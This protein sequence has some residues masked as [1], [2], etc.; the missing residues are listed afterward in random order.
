MS[1]TDSIKKS[2][3]LPTSGSAQPARSSDP[4]AARSAH[5]AAESTMFERVASLQLEDD[6]LGHN[7]GKG[8]RLLKWLAVVALLSAGCLAAY[9]TTGWRSEGF[10]AQSIQEWLLGPPQVDALVVQKQSPVPILFDTAGYL[11][12]HATVQVSPN[13]AG[14]IVGLHT[15]LGQRMKR[16]ELLA[17]LDDVTFRADFEKAKSEV[18]LAKARYDELAAG[19]RPEEVSEA[20]ALVKQAE[21]RL[22][23]AEAELTRAK[24]LFRKKVMPVHEFDQIQAT[25]DEMHENVNEL[26]QK[27]R[28][29]ELGPRDEAIAAAAAEWDR[30]KAV[31]AKMQYFFESTRVT[32]P[33]DGTILQLQAELGETVRPEAFGSENGLST[34][35]CVMADLS[36]LEVEIDIPEQEVHSVRIGQYCEVTIEA[37]PDRVYE[38]QVSRRTPV[39]NR[40]RGVVEWRVRILEPDEYLLPYMNCRVLLYE[41]KPSP[42]QLPVIRLPRET[43]YGEAGDYY[44]WVHAAEHAQRR[45][46]ALANSELLSD[47][48]T[49][50]VTVHSG[51]NDGD[52]VLLPGERLLSDGQAVRVQ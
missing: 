33:I 2:L 20:G 28:L 3:A 51:L 37:A 34:S 42:D 29:V 26:K 50:F 25:R 36:E 15:Q 6:S 41:D 38:A 19:S 35:L 18:E 16:G 30:A 39:A 45:M 10:S 46:I 43:V 1:K 32:A 9:A 11:I 52:V 22:G 12:P 8:W 44:V 24:D 14:T 23:L 5:T 27:L 47:E 31:L 17:V 4:S 40:Q 49:E 13:V 21:V 7:R 48:Q